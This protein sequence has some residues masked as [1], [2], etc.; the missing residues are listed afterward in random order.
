[1]G[2]RGKPLATKLALGN[3]GMKR[4]PT[5]AD[6]SACRRERWRRRCRTI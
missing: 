1:M 6:G 3:P 4:L 2:R 5:L